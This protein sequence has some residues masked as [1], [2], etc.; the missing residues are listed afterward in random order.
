MVALT[1]SVGYE[2]LRPLERTCLA[3]VLRRRF[4]AVQDLRA[5]APAATLSSVA[6]SAKAVGGAHG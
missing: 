5:G 2:K 4:R 6:Q 1:P 3:Q